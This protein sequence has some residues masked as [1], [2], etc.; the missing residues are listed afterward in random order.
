[1]AG[2]EAGN[3]IGTLC[4][5][6]ETKIVR[7]DPSAEPFIAYRN[8]EMANKSWKRNIFRHVKIQKYKE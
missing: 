4:A 2:G 6:L 3:A 7:V 5:S 1:M 8:G